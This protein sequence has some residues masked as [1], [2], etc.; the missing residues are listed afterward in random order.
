MR[1]KDAGSL[2]F[3]KLGGSLISDKRKPRSFRRKTVA[4]IAAEIRRALFKAPGM[5][6]LGA[7][8]GGGA[9][10]HPARKYRTREGVPGGGRVHNVDRVGGHA[11]QLAGGGD[12]HAT[13]PPELEDGGRGAP[14]DRIDSRILM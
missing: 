10:H 6:L 1:G 11:G 4:R 2:V 14:G 12:D 8:G 9:A 7:H 13:A 3:L 5:R